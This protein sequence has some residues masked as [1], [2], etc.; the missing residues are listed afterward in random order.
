MPRLTYLIALFVLLG[1]A[2]CATTQ[3]PP[4]SGVSSNRIVID[5]LPVSVSSFSAYEIVE[6]YRPHWLQKRG[7]ASF[8]APTDV[9]VYLDGNR[10]RFGPPSALRQLPAM[11]I[12]EIEHL[13]GSEAQ[14]KYGLNNIHGAIVVHTHP[15]P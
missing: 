8:N 13:S 3:R 11:D 6:H 1:T 14:A 5:E 2:A 9:A 10:S 7:P 15:G 4:Q 12:V